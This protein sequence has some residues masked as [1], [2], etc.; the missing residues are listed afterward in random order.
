VKVPVFEWGSLKAALYLRKQFQDLIELK[1]LDAAAKFTNANI[2]T[3]S[4]GHE[5]WQQARAEVLGKS[6]S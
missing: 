3:S 2:L 4:A 6:S 1:G 5:K